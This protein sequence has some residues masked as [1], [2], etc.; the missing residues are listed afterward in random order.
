MAKTA[1]CILSGGA[2]SRMG[3]DKASLRLLDGRSL[4]QL[5]VDK[6]VS[7]NCL[8]V[9]G[10]TSQPMLENNEPPT[11]P[12]LFSARKGPVGGIVS[13]VLWLQRFYP[14]IE[15]CYFV[16]VDLPCLD[17]D[18]L[19]ALENATGV[20]RFFVDHPL[21]LRLELNSQT[22]QLCATL[23]EE[24]LSLDGYAV[25]QLVAR[26]ESCGEL[27]APSS[28]SLRNFNHFYQWEQY[29]HENSI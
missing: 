5:M 24:L 19:F 27:A 18:S 13:S 23:A 1:V 29:I 4:L 21:P 20:G 8:T 28:N 15:V 17:I 14:V 25:R 16:P 11:I 12:D 2:S 22:R 9:I 10:G 6:F 26:F 7:E 3:Q